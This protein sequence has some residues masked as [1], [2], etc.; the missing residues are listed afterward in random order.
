M[1]VSE[2]TQNQIMAVLQRMVEAVAK[3]DSDS[4]TT[5]LD[6]DF[7]FLGPGGKTLRMDEFHRY[8]EHD[9][10]RVEAISLNLSDIHIS[11]EGTVAWIMTDLTC[12]VVASGAPQTHSG[13]VTAVLRGTGHAWVFAQIHLSI[14]VT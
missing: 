10:S 14:T 4:V 12:R 2:Q 1:K 5:L 11:A 13:Q 8:L 9:F 3:E 6:P 7:R